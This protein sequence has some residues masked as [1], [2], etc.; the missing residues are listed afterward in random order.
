MKYLCL[1]ERKFL[2]LFIPLPH[3]HMGRERKRNREREGERE[4]ER[5][6]ER[7]GEKC[8]LMRVLNWNSENPD[9]SDFS[10]C[11]ICRDELLVFLFVC[12][13]CCVFGFLSEN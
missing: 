13:V 7:G 12:S 11:T 4:G 9:M 5:K 10:L 3:F 1:S 6:R 2:A 8:F